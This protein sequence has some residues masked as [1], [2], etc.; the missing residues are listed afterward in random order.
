MNIVSIT[1]MRS[2]S[3]R[4]SWRDLPGDLLHRR[5]H[6]RVTGD[7]IVKDE[8]AVW[9]KM[10]RRMRP[11]IAVN[12]FKTADEITES[13]AL[14]TDLKTWAN[15]SGLELSEDG[16]RPWRSPAST[17]TSIPSTITPGVYDVTFST[18]GIGNTRSTPPIKCEE[19]DRGRLDL[20]SREDIHVMS[21]KTRGASMRT[22]S[23]QLA[24]PLC[25]VGRPDDPSPRCC[26]I[27]L[28]AFTTAGQRRR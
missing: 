21:E 6:Q 23:A 5:R 19:G 24:Y 17:T 20:L 10:R 22:D 27:L 28:Y 16:I 3:S 25:G 11:I 7:I 4:R 14:D 18:D 1:R 15:A 9:P 26:M 13:V 8:S 12:F 2:T